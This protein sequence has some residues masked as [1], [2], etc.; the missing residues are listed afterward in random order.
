MTHQGVIMSY[1][2][3]YAISNIYY[4]KIYSQIPVPGSVSCRV[5]YNIY[6]ILRDIKCVLHF[7]ACHVGCDTK[8]NIYY[9]L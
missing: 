1:V 6:L 2:L 5:S 9:I 7:V 3:Y 8:C 4:I